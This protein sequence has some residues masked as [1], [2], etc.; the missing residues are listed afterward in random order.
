MQK[1]MRQLLFSQGAALVGVADLGELPAEVRAEMPIG[2]SIAVALDPRIIGRIV[3]GPTLE[4]EAEY[5]RVNTKLGQLAE[6]G[7][8]FLTAAGYRAQA[9]VPTTEQLPPGLAFPLPHKTVATRAGLG[10]IGKTGLLVTHEYGSAVRLATILTDAPLRPA[11]PIDRSR[12]GDCALCV[13]ACPAGA[14][15]GSPW[16]KGMAREELL[17]AQKCLRSIRKRMPGVGLT[18]TVCGICVAVCPWTQKYVDGQQVSGAG[19][20]GS[21]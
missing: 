15:S 10:W 2:V 1:Q 9:L 21:G 7:A 20:E 4:Y 8:A 5:R 14:A 11:K 12:C 13:E 19:G 18:H 3:Q 6:A 17:D 16:H